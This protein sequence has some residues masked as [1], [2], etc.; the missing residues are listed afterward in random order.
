MRRCTLNKA[1]YLASGDRAIH[2]RFILQ[3]CPRKLTHRILFIILHV[4]KS[5][6]GRK[7]VSEQTMEE[8]MDS[9]CLLH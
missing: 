4:I 8:L 2:K 9:Q 6:V 3:E 5:K 7:L 1:G